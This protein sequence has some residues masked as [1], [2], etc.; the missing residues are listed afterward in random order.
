MFRRRAGSAACRGAGG[1][2]SVP[3]PVEVLYFPEIF[4]NTV[5]GTLSIMNKD[6]IIVPHVYLQYRSPSCK[7][8]ISS[9]ISVLKNSLSIQIFTVGILL[10]FN[11]RKISLSLENV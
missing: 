3:G 1:G 6:S 11:L 5:N 7:F 2:A 9:L 8:L 10:E 4:I